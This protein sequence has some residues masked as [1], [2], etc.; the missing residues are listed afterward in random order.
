MED[1]K[2]K[3]GRKKIRTNLRNETCTLTYCKV[4][5]KAGIYVGKGYSIMRSDGN[6]IPVL[7]DVRQERELD[8]GFYEIKHSSE[9]SRLVVVCWVKQ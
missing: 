1:I 7:G 3:V 9:E 6:V 8:E 2:S 5:N 4:F